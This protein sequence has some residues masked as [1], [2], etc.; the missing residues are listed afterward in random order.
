MG[1]ACAVAAHWL[2]KKPSTHTSTPAGKQPTTPDQS[3][4][5][6]EQH[7]ERSTT[8][9]D[10][11]LSSLT[12]WEGGLCFLAILDSQGRYKRF[13]VF[14]EACVGAVQKRLVCVAVVLAEETQCEL[15]R[16][17]PILLLCFRASWSGA[18]LARTRV[19]ID[20]PPPIES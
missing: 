10:L 4:Q 11:V 3:K 19:R 16:L 8:E 7:T 5:T 1:P 17:G 15:K 6:H 20:P 13:S 12:P 2:R 9:L 18:S 14:W